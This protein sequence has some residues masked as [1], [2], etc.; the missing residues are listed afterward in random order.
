MISD[1]LNPILKTMT[2]DP[3][4]YKDYGTPEY[5]SNMLRDGIIGAGLGAVGGGGQVVRAVGETAQSAKARNAEST[6]STQTPAQPVDALQVIADMV[7]G[8][9]ST[10]AEETARLFSREK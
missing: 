10:D 8:K 2:Y 6:Q 5:W 7:T 9:A 4:G 1:V 3:E